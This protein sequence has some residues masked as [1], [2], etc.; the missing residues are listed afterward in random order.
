M[1]TPRIPFQNYTHVAL[2]GKDLGVRVRD[3]L[4]KQASYYRVPYRPRT[5]TTCLPS[6]AS[7]DW[8]TLHNEPLK[9]RRHAN[10]HEYDE[11]VRNAEREGRRVYGVISPVQQFMAETVTPECGMPLD[12]LRTV[13]LDIE[14]G[15][16]GGFAPPENPFQPI[17]AIT[18]LVWG[19]Y[20]VWGC[21]SYAP[22]RDN[23]TYIQC[24]NETELLYS[25]LQWWTSDYPDIVSG[26]NVQGYD[27]PYIV[28]RLDRMITE[29]QFPKKYSKSILSPWRKLS[30]RHATIMGRDAVLIELVG[31]S[32]LDYLELYRKFSLTQRESYRLDA[33][34]EAELG[35]KKIAYDEYGSLQ[36]LA[37]EN[38]QKFIDYNI[39]DVELVQQLNDKLHHIDLA[40]QIAYGARVNFLD[41]FK[42]VRLWDA[43]MYYDLYDRH[44]AV[45]QKTKSAKAVEF[46][47]AYVKDPITGKH[48]WVVSFDV[49]SL[50]PSIMRQ[51]N[52]S[53]D[54]HLTLEWLKAKLEDVECL[55]GANELL[56]GVTPR[57]EA[58]TPREWLTDIK[59][60]DVPIVAWA[61][62][63][64]IA[65]L[66]HTSMDRMLADLTT[67]DP[68]PWLRVLSVCITPNGQAFRSDE[69]GFLP[70]ILSR[71]YS[72]RKSAKNKET[73]AKKLAA[74][75]ETPEKK[76]AYEREAVM[77][78]LQQNTRKINLN[79]CYGALGSE[80]HRFFDVRHAEA[81]TATG[82]VIIQ[83]VAHQVNAFLNAEFGTTT[84]Y[85]LASDTDSIYVKLAPVVGDMSVAA[86]VDH[87]DRYCENDLQRVIDAAFQTIG[88]HFNTQDNVLAMKREAIAEYGVWTAK[89]RY[90]LWVHDNEGVRYNP[91]K[92]KMTGIEAV[93]SSTPKYAREV[94]KKALEYFIQGH[95][96]EFYTLIDTAEEG[97]MSRP[98]E[99]I[100]SPR[101]V[102][103]LDTYDP[104]EGDFL[105]AT[106]IHV[107]GAITYNR[108]LE[109]T[110]LV[111][112]Y[113]KIRNSEKIR[114]CYLKPQ[115]P[116]RTT[117]IAAPN[118]LPPEWKLERY[119]DRQLQFEKSVL[120][121]LEHIVR[122][123]GWPIRPMVTLDF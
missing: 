1:Q 7:N 56:T 71:L 9:E 60:A 40:V 108:H 43:M 83:Y 17:I 87:L 107:K 27:I 103:G 37:E 100:A 41:T 31:V 96:Q 5:F 6:H 106:P 62:R 13:Y 57:V 29:G 122:E 53:P 33:I 91:P 88:N 79:S 70:N 48:S 93:R 104:G 77:W 92:L 84:D 64:L 116:L 47:G 52:I 119:L 23:V 30:H 118:A 114:F 24:A 90:L 58:C 59:S 16:A 11:Y 46:T 26:W 8:R 110:N 67:P 66:E 42:Q 50:Y 18:A 44:I 111:Q 12:S 28:N 22:T 36:R 81:V 80:H 3:P 73:K 39:V 82:Q 117:V 21:G 89:K 86:A 98:F 2:L 72:E 105:P 34:A 54:R 14:V 85:V 115:N 20:T 45:P 35:K 120:S 102:N 49:N 63:E 55:R 4:T 51:W 75:A 109:K 97:F 78:G 19:H 101:S 95:Q 123:A 69:R 65:Y 25:F 68:W 61:L 94:I 15:S 38:Y 99:D 10:I 112:K 32:V 113:P 76:L 74:T 121:P